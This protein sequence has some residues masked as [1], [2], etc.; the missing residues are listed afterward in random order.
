MERRDARIYAGLC[1]DSQRPI[2][3]VRLAVRLHL[4]VGER[5]RTRSAK[6]RLRFLRSPLR[7]DQTLAIALECQTSLSEST[8]P[9]RLFTD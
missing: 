2:W 4:G 5:R 6:R 9:E 8:S 1:Y 7:F 3:P